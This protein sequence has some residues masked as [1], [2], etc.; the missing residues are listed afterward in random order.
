MYSKRFGAEGDGLLDQFAL[1]L[2]LF[3]PLFDEAV[4]L[5]KQLG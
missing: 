2:R 3:M 5:A 4:S 1:R